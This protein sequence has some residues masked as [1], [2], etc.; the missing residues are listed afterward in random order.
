M[1]NLQQR[2][3]LLNLDILKLTN[4]ICEPPEPIG[5]KYWVNGKLTIIPLTLIEIADW[6]KDIPAVW[7]F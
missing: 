4:E 7:L 2:I 6:K 1:K 5:I 3:N